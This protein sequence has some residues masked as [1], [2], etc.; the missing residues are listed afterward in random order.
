MGGIRSGLEKE[1]GEGIVDACASQASLGA[2]R[3]LSVE[4]LS[5][6]Q[7]A[8]QRCR[9]PE[10]LSGDGV[11]S[12]EELP[13]LRAAAR[14]VERARRTILIEHDRRGPHHLETIRMPAVLT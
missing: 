13:G 14:T 10:F 3:W 8:T 11:F 4:T 7:Q 5:D 2:F 12:F 6:R 1:L 9:N